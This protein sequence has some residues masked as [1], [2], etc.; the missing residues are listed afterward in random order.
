MAK[1]V[2]LIILISFIFFLVTAVVFQSFWYPGITKQQT[3]NVLLGDQKLGFRAMDKAKWHGASIIDDFAYLTNE[4]ENIN[5]YQASVI[6]EFLNDINTNKILEYGKKLYEKEGLYPRLFGALI[7]SKSSERI[8][9][10][11][12]FQF[13]VDVATRRYRNLK[14]D[15]FKSRDY[16][17]EI[18][19]LSIGN[20]GTDEAFQLLSRI[21]NEKDVPHVRHRIT[22]YALGNLGDKRA[23]DLL[24]KRMM[25]KDF[26]ATLSAYETLLKLDDSQVNEYAQKRVALGFGGDDVFLSGH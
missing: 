17:S 22:N 24:H 14:K 21:L 11:G 4:Y 26:K 18:A 10:K 7:L 3:A 6:S 8:N 13:L 1:Y 9:Y 20:Y 12:M 16:Y 15:L 5:Y 23:I 2:K 25:D 19:I